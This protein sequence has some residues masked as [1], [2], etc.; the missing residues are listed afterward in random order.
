MSIRYQV[1]IKNDGMVI[2]EVGTEGEAVQLIKDFERED[3][4]MNQYQPGSYKIEH[5]GFEDEWVAL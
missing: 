4:E 5:V 1:K 2:D 3:K